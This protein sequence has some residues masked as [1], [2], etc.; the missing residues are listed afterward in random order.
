[1]GHAIRRQ[2]L[3]WVREE[4]ERTVQEIEAD[5]YLPLTNQ[6]IHWPRRNALCFPVFQDQNEK[7]DTLGQCGDSDKRDGSM[8]SS[9]SS[10]CESPNILNL[11]PSG[12]ETEIRTAMTSIEVGET[13]IGATKLASTSNLQPESLQPRSPPFL[14]R[15]SFSTLPEVQETCRPLHNTDEPQ[16]STL[17]F[18]ATRS[19]PRAQPE[20][21]PLSS[22]AKL[23]ASVI[24]QPQWRSDGIPLLETDA[25]GSWLELPKPTLSDLPQD[26]ESLT[27]LKA[28]LAMELLWIKQ[29]IASRQNVSISVVTVQQTTVR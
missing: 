6:V 18:S 17:P 16:A 7:V 13:H 15:M 10:P 22:C 24:D 14:E 8:N 29:A 26:R 19:S 28:Q 1:M 20:N 3:H 4:Y 2:L 25:V 11:E 9:A 5:S 12:S 27:K 23:S 21:L